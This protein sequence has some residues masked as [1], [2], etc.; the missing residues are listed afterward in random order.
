MWAFPG[1]EAAHH[2]KNPTITVITR[3]TLIPSAHQCRGFAAV[4]LARPV[5]I[6][7]SAPLWAAAMQPLERRFRA[8]WAPSS[9]AACMV[10]E[11]AGFQMFL[12]SCKLKCQAR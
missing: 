5:G 3:G 9:A 12:P 10:G 1:R 8:P 4:P 6:P 2:L 7:L 11:S